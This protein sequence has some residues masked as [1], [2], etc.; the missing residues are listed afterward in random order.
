MKQVKEA[1]TV[2]Q[3]IQAYLR[4]KEIFFQVQKESSTIIKK[5]TPKE[6]SILIGICGEKIERFIICIKTEERMSENKLSCIRISAKEVLPPLMNPYI[7]FP[8]LETV[9]RLCNECKMIYWGYNP[10]TFELFPFTELNIE[11]HFLTE[12]LFF[13]YLTTFIDYVDTVLWSLMQFIK[14][15]KNRTEKV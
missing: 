13:S 2:L 6:N 3:I 1:M 15:S 12:E 7:R 10:E 4:K 14:E 5:N 8:M 11:S 9:L